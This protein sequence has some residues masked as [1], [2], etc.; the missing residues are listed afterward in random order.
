[1]KTR[2][3]AKN[4]KTNKRKSIRGGTP[5][6][7]PTRSAAK[8]YHTLPREVR[9]LINDYVPSYENIVLRIKQGRN[10]ENIKKSLVLALKND[11]FLSRLQD[12]NYEG[13]RIASSIAD[14]RS[15]SSSLSFL[16]PERVQILAKTWIYVIQHRVFFDELDKLFNEI[17]NAPIG[18]A[19]AEAKEI[20]MYGNLRE[21]LDVHNIYGD[22][23]LIK[24]MMAYLKTKLI[25]KR[26][27]DE[28]YISES[29]D[30]IKKKLLVRADN[31]FVNIF[32]AR[33]K[34][35]NTQRLSSIIAPSRDNDERNFSE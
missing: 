15:S 25:V 29:I 5:T 4:R 11:A 32:I 31:I 10:D 7:S 30:T 26:R 2:K 9:N 22:K 21:F 19:R 1:M 13:F 34:S 28:E 18:E 14:C 8:K 20:K 35:W 27:A 16:T 23:D 6:S 24:M 12:H 3:N 17:L 33:F